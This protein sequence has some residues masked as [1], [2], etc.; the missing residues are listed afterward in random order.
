MTTIKKAVKILN[1]NGGTFGTGAGTN[2]AGTTMGP[3]MSMAD[4]Q[5]NT[6][7]PQPGQNLTK[8]VVYFTDGLMNTMQDTFNCPVAKLINYGGYDVAGNDIT[9]T[10]EFFDPTNGTDWG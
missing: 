9:T 2:A 5:N 8:V 4:Q 7:N 6:V 10:P 1:F 3:P